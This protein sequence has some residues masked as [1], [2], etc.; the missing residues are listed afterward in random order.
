MQETYTDWTL[1]SLS[2]LSLGP[3][4]LCVTAVGVT[5]AAVLWSYRHAKGRA[6]LMLLRAL[7][8]L[9]VLGF[10]VEPAVQ[11]RAVRKI[12][13]RLAVVLDRSR[14]MALAT[15][16]GHT[17]YENVLQALERSRNSLAT[18]GASHSVDWFDLGGPLSSATLNTPPTGERSDLLLGL[19]RAREAGAGKPLAGIVLISDGADNAELEGKERGKLSGPAVERLGRLGAPVNVVS[20]AQAQT[21]R[22]VSVEQVVSDEF[23][24]VHNTLEIEVQLEATGFDTLTVPV[25]LRREGDILATQEAALKPDTPTKV[26]FKTKPDKIGEF[27]Y[28]V[29]V[30]EF[31]GEAIRTNNQQSFVLQVIRDKI[32]VLQVAGR[33][34]WDERFLRQHLKENPNADLISFFILR[35]PTDDP[36]VPEQELSLIPFPVNKL[37]T[38][39]LRS[40]DV[41][42]FQNF[43]Y[44]PY[45]MAHFLPNIRDAVKEGLG[46]VMIGGEESFAGGG[47]LGTAIDEILPVR[48]DQGSLASGA[49]TATLTES[50]RRHPVT[51]LTRGQGNNDTA[52]KNLPKWTSVN[53]T[54]GLSPGATAL[55]VDNDQHTGGGAA[56]PLIAAMDV[57]Q[58]R[59]LAITTD[60]MWRWRFA[61]QHDGGAS[62]RAYHRFW[63]NA[64]RWLVRDPEHSRVRVLP[65]KRRFEVNEPVD[66]TFVVLGKD[67]QPMPFAHVRTTLEQTGKP[68]SRIDD[69]VAGETG[70]A[71]YRYTDLS[72]GPFRVTATASA[73]QESLGQ[74]TGVFVVES[75]SLELTRGAPRADLLEAIA[76]QTKGASLELGDTF[77]DDLKLV[78]PDVVEIDKR[79][80][81]ELW[82]NGWALAA[83][84]ALFAVEWALR[85]RRGYL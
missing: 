10:L 46:F 14:S 58:G 36:S 18:L 69:I 30:P 9:L 34:S 31:S 38:T 63:S 32:R 45:R 64:L 82:D 81:V 47:Y 65:E 62:E 43:D 19:E 15:E 77:W 44:R 6:T 8:A 84:V 59:S 11:L 50:G 1:V 25:T 85:R 35:T 53:L 56:A 5:C 73:G 2:P 28:T 48:I 79:R 76:A 78:D 51:D 21:F 23:A 52:W 16:S 3:L 24:F 17:R 80:N 83:G 49:V 42:I 20:V 4:L 27:V 60:S 29:S 66:V 57:G 22:D 70:V 54:G 67:Y 13:N 68:Q 40:F 7:T 55:V 74:G 37:F 33:P 75:R 26:L 39:E 41:V 61:S 72:A 71:R 12:K